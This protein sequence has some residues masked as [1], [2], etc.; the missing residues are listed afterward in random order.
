MTTFNINMQQRSILGEPISGP[1]IC[2]KA[3]IINKKLGGDP[4]FKATTGWLQKFKLRHGIRPVSYTHL[5][6]YKRQ[7]KIV[8]NM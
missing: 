1:I 5:D 4:H 6:V 8:I 7:H 3:F 2:E